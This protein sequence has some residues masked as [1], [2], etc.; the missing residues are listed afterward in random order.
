MVV[1]KH[2]GCSGFEPKRSVH[3]ISYKNKLFA[4]IQ[5]NILIA[6]FCLEYFILNIQ[7]FIKFKVSKCKNCG[8]KNKW[9]PIDKAKANPVVV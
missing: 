6:N 8:P 7:N 9:R 1:Y 4:Q 2:G 5:G 3:S